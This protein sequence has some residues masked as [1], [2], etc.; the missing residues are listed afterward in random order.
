L[1]GWGTDTPSPAA[2]MATM[3]S[4]GERGILTLGRSRK[5]R[6]ATH[7]QVDDESVHEAL[8]AMAAILHQERSAGGCSSA[9]ASTTIERG[10]T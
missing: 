2:T 4:L 7:A 6:F 8:E 10:T 3:A 5:I 1:R 9:R